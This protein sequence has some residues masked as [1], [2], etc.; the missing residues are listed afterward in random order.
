MFT[1]RQRRMSIKT[2]ACESCKR[3]WGISGKGRMHAIG[4]I[5]R[6]Q[7]CH[8]SRKMYYKSA[9]KRWLE[10]FYCTITHFCAIF[11]HTPLLRKCQ[12]DQRTIY[13]NCGQTMTNTVFTRSACLVAFPSV[14]I[15]GEKE[16]SPL[17]SPTVCPPCSH[18]AW[19]SAGRVTKLLLPI[20]YHL[21][22]KEALDRNLRKYSVTDTP[23][24]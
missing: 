23:P 10:Q 3:C 11:H 21:S 14:F 6:D 9:Q 22:N 15:P 4:G 20:S 17:F 16:L 8:L 7:T 18:C 5:S 19:L 24:R 2:G 1:S 12:H 13:H